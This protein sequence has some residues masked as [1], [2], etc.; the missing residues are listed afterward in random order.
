MNQTI[1]FAQF[2]ESMAAIH[3][4]PRLFEGT[5][6]QYDCAWDGHKISAGYDK[7][8]P[9][10]P[11]WV[12][13]SPVMGLG[14]YPLQEA[15]FFNRS[16]LKYLRA[17]LISEDGVYYKLLWRVSPEAQTLV[18]WEQDM[19]TYIALLTRAQRLFTALP[20]PNPCEIYAH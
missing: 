10:A 19:K 14:K 18:K 3:Q 6:V 11:G 4:L 5:K 12:L 1:T 20:S 16:S 15:L 8:H 13:S 2:L 7:I 9:T 17:G